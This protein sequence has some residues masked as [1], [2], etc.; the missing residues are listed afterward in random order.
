MTLDT[1][2]V[3]ISKLLDGFD[4]ETFY[5][6]L[7]NKLA[8]LPNSTTSYMHYYDALQSLIASSEGWFGFKEFLRFH[9]RY[10]AELVENESVEMI[11]ERLI[12]TLK[13]VEQGVN[14][15]QGSIESVTFYGDSPDGSRIIAARSPRGAYTIDN[16]RF[17]AFEQ[18]IISTAGGL[19]RIVHLAIHERGSMIETIKGAV[20]KAY[21]AKNRQQ[22]LTGPNQ[23]TLK[24]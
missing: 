11:T 17:S 14:F 7:R 18:E 3:R 16:A 24:A 20:L 19:E 12:E 5:E 4:A 21:L 9:R 2:Y 6:E 22:T 23:H 8:E 13:I 1:L 15:E 10:T